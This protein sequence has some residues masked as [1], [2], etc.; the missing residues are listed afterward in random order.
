LAAEIKSKK[1]V[2][3]VA[4]VPG[5]RGSFEVFK[6]GRCVFS[7]LELGRFPHSEAE[8]LALLDAQL[9]SN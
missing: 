7:K 9:G 2:P 1:G 4:V 6:D 5:A 3:D 8:V